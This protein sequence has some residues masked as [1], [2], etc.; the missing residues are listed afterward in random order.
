MASR[1]YM[2]ATGWFGKVGGS[3]ESEACNKAM[4]CP[5]KGCVFALVSLS[6]GSDF[7]Q[8]DKCNIERNNKKSM[9]IA[10]SKLMVIKAKAS[11]II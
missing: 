4:D 5:Y 10:I 9:R 8:A 7:E 6:T 1:L 3:T 2:A 11:A